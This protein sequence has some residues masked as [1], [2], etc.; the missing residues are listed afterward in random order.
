MDAWAFIGYRCFAVLLISLDRSPKL[1]AS[2]IYIYKYI[3]TYIH[4]CMRAYIHTC[5]HAWIHTYIHTYIHN[6]ISTWNKFSWTADVRPVLD[7]VLRFD[8]MKE[9]SSRTTWLHS[10]RMAWL[11]VLTGNP[12]GRTQSCAS[13][14]D[15]L[16]PHGESGMSERWNLKCK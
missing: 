15:T 9:H 4:T 14:S 3:R 11:W 5:M 12:T 13:C 1:P 6:K 7:V 2:H 16:G 8:P 10:L